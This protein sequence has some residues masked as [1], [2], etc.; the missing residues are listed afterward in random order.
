MDLEIQNLTFTYP[1]QPLLLE[2]ITYRFPS[3]GLTVIAGQ[4]GSGKS[5]LL[6]LLAGILAPSSG[7]VQLNHQDVSL[8]VPAARVQH[9]AYLPQNTRHF[10][11][12]KTGREQLSFMLEN[13]QTPSDQIPKIIHQ[14]VAENSLEY[15]V[16]QPITTLSGG[17]LQQM[18]LAMIFSLDPEYL[19]LD[20]P[21]A[22]LDHDHQL[23]LIHMLKSKKNN[24]AIIVADHQLQYYQ[25]FADSW[26]NVT[27]HKLQSFNPSF[28]NSPTVSRVTAG[29]PVSIS[30]RLQW[31]KLTFSQAGRPLV[32]ESTFQ[33]PQ[34][35]VGLLAGKN[36]S[37]KST[38]LNVL[39]KQYPYSGQI[40]FDQQNE[41]RISIRKW[42]QHITLGFQNSEDQFIKTTVREELQS[43]QQA[44]YHPN[45]WTNLQISSWVQKF[46]LQSIIDESPYFISGGQQKK[47][48]LLILAIISSPVILLDEILTGLD[49][50][51]VALA[52]DLIEMLTQLGCGILI[53]DHQ[54]QS[55]KHYDYVLEIHDSHLQLLPKGESLN[56]IDH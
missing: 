48:Q 52:W 41:Q 6:Q 36:G 21:F 38:L 55:F 35:M 39:T 42:I 13:L 22:N 12:F 8:I 34:R 17:E 20:E 16:D 51:S 5:T 19:L 18:A 9:L 45:F 2:N 56:E 24:T 37:G 28:Q 53:I 11:T 46:N 15:L 40:T 54:F 44:S 43:A 3:T 27:V 29:L 33:L 4:N 47:V 10:F 50:A 1:T 23:Q 25:D 32:V 26:L 31:Q 49:H 30:S 14:I 7:K